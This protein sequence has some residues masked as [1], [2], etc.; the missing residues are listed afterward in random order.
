MVKGE[1]I[2]SVTVN[3][4]NGEEVLTAFVTIPKV[5]ITGRNVKKVLIFT[6]VNITESD[7]DSDYAGVIVT[8]VFGSYEVSKTAE[9]VATAGL[10]TIYGWLKTELE[11]QNGNTVSE[12]TV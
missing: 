4:T 8:N 3:P 7:F 2:T 6:K 12:I 11:T 5:Q 9:E 10:D 1:K